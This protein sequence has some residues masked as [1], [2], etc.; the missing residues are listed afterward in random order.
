MKRKAFL[1]LLTTPVLGARAEANVPLRKDF[2]GTWKADIPNSD[3]GSFPVP[4]SFV[5]TIQ[6]DDLHLT[7]GAVVPAGR[8]CTTLLD[9]GG[10][11]GRVPSSMISYFQIRRGQ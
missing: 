6:E 7:P 2:S 3:F 5:R 4:K 10:A 11:G 1:L 9:G 8:G